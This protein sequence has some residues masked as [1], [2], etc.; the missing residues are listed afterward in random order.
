MT[1]PRPQS[2]AD[3]ADWEARSVQYM[4]TLIELERAGERTTLSVGPLGAMQLIGMLQLVTRHPDLS[5]VQ[6]Q[7]ARDIVGQLA[8]LFAG[9]FGEEIV[10][11]G[12]HPEWDK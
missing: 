5:P 7:I 9:T 11:R 10:R 8:P 12:N 3:D 6:H 1:M 4:R 2:D